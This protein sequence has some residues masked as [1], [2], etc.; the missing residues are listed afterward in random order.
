MNKRSEQVCR[1]Y[2]T[3]DKRSFYS[4]DVGSTRELSLASFPTI[5]ECGV[6]MS[7]LVEMRSFFEAY[8]TYVSDVLDPNYRTVKELLKEWEGPDYWA[9]V[10]REINPTVADRL[11]SPSP[12]QRVRVRIKRPESVMDKIFRKP[13]SFPDG[14]QKDSFELMEDTLGARIVVY[15]LA[16]LPLVNHK[17]QSHPQ[18]EISTTK[19]PVAYLPA[20]LFER[21][22]LANM[23]RSTKESGY[24][25]IHY[26]VRLRDDRVPEIHRPWFEIQVRTIVEDAWS[27]VEHI[28]GYKPGRHTSLAVRKQFQIISKLLVAIDEHFNFLGDELTRFQIESSVRNENPLNAENLPT[29]LAELSLGCAQKEIDG[30]LKVMASRGI[31]SVGE[32]RQVGT[33]GTVELI[34]HTYLN[35]VGRQPSNFEIVANLANLAGVPT[36]SSRLDRIRAQIEFLDLWVQMKGELRGG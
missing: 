32:L 22:A 21:L 18:L 17:I 24:A 26:I 12:V 10:L 14:L 23:D 4:E 27:E 16:H 19:R 25:S 1:V 7:E 31:N 3:L 9:S 33:P 8:K 29:V 30:L 11:P 6:E 2:G 15:F 13:T 34:R 20:E 28:L 35:T 5:E 36:H